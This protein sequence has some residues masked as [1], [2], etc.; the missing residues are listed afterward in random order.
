MVLIWTMAKK[1]EVTK[2]LASRNPFSCPKTVYKIRSKHR[3]RTP[4]EHL[5]ILKL[6]AT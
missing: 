6:R 5:L 2:Q 1:L 4:R 3:R